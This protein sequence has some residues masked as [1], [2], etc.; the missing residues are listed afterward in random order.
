MNNRLRAGTVQSTGA[1]VDVEA[2]IIHNVSVIEIGPAM[3]HSFDVDETT[4]AQVIELGNRNPNGTKVRLSHPDA[5]NDGTGRELGRNRNHRLSDD[6]NRVLADFH[7]MKAASL[8]PDGDLTGWLM[9][10]AQEDPGMIGMS[11]AAAGKAEP[12]LDEE[13]DPKVGPNGEKLRPVLRITKLI[14]TDV[15]DQPAANR[16][17]LFASAAL[18]TGILEDLIHDDASFASEAELTAAFLES[19]DLIRLA[20][21][22]ELDVIKLG[23]HALDFDR[24]AGFINHHLDR[25]EIGH[26]SLDAAAVRRIVHSLQEPTA[27]P[28]TVNAGESRADYVARC[29]N[30]DGQTPETLGAAWDVNPYAGKPPTKPAAATATDTS[31]AVAAECKRGQEIRALGA[32]FQDV[33]KAKELADKLAIDTTVDLAEAR[34]QIMDIVAEAH[35]APTAEPSLE[36]GATASEKLLAQASDAFVLA[37]GITLTGDDV[38]KRTKQAQ[39]SGLI[40]LGP[41]RVA[42]L[43]LKN[44]GVRG[45]DTMPP[46]RLFSEAMGISLAGVGHTTADFPL[47]LADSAS[48]AMIS[49]Y[50][51]APVTWD[52]WVKIGNLRDFK[53]AS[54]LRLS[55]APLLE[56]RPEGEPA[57]QGTFNE[58][59]EQITLLN[60]AKAVSYTRQMFI[61]DD[62]GAFAT[63]SAALGAGANYSVERDLYANLTLN[64]R[65]GPTMSD[66]TVLFHANHNNLAAS[67]GV[68]TQARLEAAIADMMNQAGIGQDGDDV[69]IGV[70]P[71]IFFAGPAVAMLLEKIVKSDW[72][73]SDAS[74]DPQIDEIAN[75]RV[76]KIAQLVNQ[77]AT[78]DWYAIA[79][80][81]L[82]PSYEV[83]FLNGNRT[84]RVET[85]RHTTVDGTTIVVSS[86]YGIFPT[87]GWQGIWRNAG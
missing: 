4:L 17:G 87:G 9:A 59:R 66:A 80:Q 15:V 74:R 12:R 44:A 78:T 68:P 16:A 7:A 33:P 45:V 79:P 1:T 42:M 2:G 20:S 61:N 67:A 75:A 83:A 11:I 36:L 48:K 86:D 73:G 10:V 23:S 3:G 26:P 14:G 24:V 53:T 40:A 81:V 39:A 29:A 47:I 38:E 8:S 58:Q 70:P 35:K 18:A 41:Q 84:P 65:T 43:C 13:G 57:R 27:M 60:Y 30:V 82:A 71:T 34:R 85:L 56:E 51:L 22:Q 46:E 6:R 62:L 49:G 54:R 55:E 37:G 77:G 50:D 21:V 5:C 76:I 19:P 25:R 63:L 32:M 64:A 72:A 28:P 52:M 69:A 31:D